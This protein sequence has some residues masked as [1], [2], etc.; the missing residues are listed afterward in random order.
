MGRK[1]MESSCG[2]DKNK[3]KP[4][5]IRVCRDTKLTDRPIQ[6]Y[7]NNAKDAW[8]SIKNRAESEEQEVFYV[9]NLDSQMSVLGISEVARGTANNLGVHLRDIFRAAIILGSV[10]IIVA[11]NHPSGRLDPS[12][13]DIE[14]TRQSLKS[15][16]LLG[17]KVI[18][19]V[20]VT[21]K[22][23]YSFEEAGFIEDSNGYTGYSED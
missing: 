17:I 13:S 20:I 21:A 14:L 3:K 2:I 9:I 12:D 6:N 10:Y 11:H 16:E 18:D 23:Y 5:W 1:H 19:H 4:E 22:G 8:K 15:G 7:I